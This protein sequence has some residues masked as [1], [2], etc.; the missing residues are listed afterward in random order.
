MAGISW[1]SRKGFIRT[2]NHSVNSGVLFSDEFGG[3][4]FVNWLRDTRAIAKES[5]PRGGRRLTT[6]HAGLRTKIL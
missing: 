2:I 6:W 1:W 4:V 3:Y 5:P